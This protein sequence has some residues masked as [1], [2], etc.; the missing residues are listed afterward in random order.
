MEKHKKNHIQTYFN[1]LTLPRE[2]ATLISC[3]YYD[4]I[5][6]QVLKLYIKNHNNPNKQDTIPVLKQSIDKIMIFWLTVEPN[7]T[8]EVKQLINQAISGSI[9]LDINKWTKSIREEAGV[10]IIYT[11]LHP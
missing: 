6:K 2:S 3:I 4:I 11:K 5:V 8:T 10:K 9:T 1:K 7:H